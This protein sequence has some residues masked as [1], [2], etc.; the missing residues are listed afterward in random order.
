[1]NPGALILISPYISLKAI[2]GG[3]AGGL[4]SW[5]SCLFKDRF[6]NLRVIREVTCPTLILHGEDDRLIPY[7]HS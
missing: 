2:I 7:S 5:V 1:M 3:F 4:M 6:K